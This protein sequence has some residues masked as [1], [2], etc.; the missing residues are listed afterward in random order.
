MGLKKE[1]QKKPVF[2]AL[3]VLL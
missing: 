1:E 3:P 2:V